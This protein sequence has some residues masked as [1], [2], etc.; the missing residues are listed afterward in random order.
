MRMRNLSIMLKITGVLCFVAALI[1]GIWF[2]TQVE[3][4]SGGVFT[5]MAWMV[6]GGVFCMLAFAVGYHLDAMADIRDKLCSSDNPQVDASPAAANSNPASTTTSQNAE[7]TNQGVVHD[8][9]IACPNCGLKQRP[10]RPNCV[11]CGAKLHNPG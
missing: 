4:V 7:K 5:F 9:Y 2:V 10:I 8:G 3:T 6:G 11:E 1:C